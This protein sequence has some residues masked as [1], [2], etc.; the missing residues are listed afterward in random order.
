MKGGPRPRSSD[1]DGC[2]REQVGGPSSSATQPGQRGHRGPWNYPDPSL[3]IWAKLV[4]HGHLSWRRLAA[5]ST[6][7]LA[8]G[9]V[10]ASPARFFL[11]LRAKRK[12]AVK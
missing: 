3:G 10:K 2:E 11:Y 5:R 7:C 6:I 1:P 8:M 4:L 12:S 9:A